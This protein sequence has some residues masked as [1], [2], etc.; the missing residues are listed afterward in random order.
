M[1]QYCVTA[2]NKDMPLSADCV[3]SWIICLTLNTAISPRRS[4]NAAWEKLKGASE[5]DAQSRY[6]ELIRKLGGEF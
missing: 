4:T 3:L 2:L 6:I 5:E 1:T